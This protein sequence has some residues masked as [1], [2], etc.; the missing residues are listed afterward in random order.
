GPDERDESIYEPGCG[1]DGH[2]DRERVEPEVAL[3]YI[4]PGLHDQSQSHTADGAVDEGADRA[5]PPGADA[6]TGEHTT[7]DSADGQGQ[8]GDRQTRAG[9]IIIRQRH[10]LGDLHLRHL[11]RRGVRAVVPAGAVS[12]GRGLSRRGGGDC[13]LHLLLHLLG[14]FLQ[15]GDDLV[16]DLLLHLGADGRKLLSHG[17]RGRFGREDLRVL[18]VDEEGTID[19]TL[20]D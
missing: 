6:H 19:L 9:G 16:V 18:V 3:E 7:D 11:R 1:R 20:A 12:L 4:E 5:H 14:A 10:D 17:G 13:V 8:T 15:T 2:S